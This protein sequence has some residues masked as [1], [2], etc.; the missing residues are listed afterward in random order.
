MKFYTET[1]RREYGETPVKDSR[2]GE[3]ATITDRRE[4]MDASD[5]LT[6]YRCIIVTET[7]SEI[8]FQFL[9][10]ANGCTLSTFVCDF[11]T[12]EKI[13]A[14]QLRGFLSGSINNAELI[15]TL[16]RL[17]SEYMDGSEV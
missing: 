8:G 5:F 2:T 17:Q 13:I 6:V 11:A 12:G 14:E 3:S 9:V 10:M 7:A 16:E 1:G 4:I 15:A